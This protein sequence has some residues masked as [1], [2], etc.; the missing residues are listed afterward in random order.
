MALSKEQIKNFC[1]KHKKGIIAAGTLT[2]VTV[3]GMAIRKAKKLPFTDV[4]G[5]LISAGSRDLPIPEK[6]VGKWHSLWVDGSTKMLTGI[7]CDVPMQYMGDLGAEILDHC[8]KH[9]INEICHDSH[10]QMVLE[11]VNDVVE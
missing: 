4:V 1:K 10:V 11:F 8:A 2:L 9:G 5:E 6:S 7:V 3:G